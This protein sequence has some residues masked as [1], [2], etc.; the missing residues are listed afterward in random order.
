MT[1]TEAKQALARKLDIDYSDIA[2]NGLWT[3]SD[4]GGLI[5]FGVEKA[6]DFKPW[7]FTEDTDTAAS[8]TNTDYYDHPADLM[9]GS[10]E[11]LMVGGNEFTKLSIQAYL[12]YF[13]DNPTGT[14]KIWAERE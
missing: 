14:D 13:Q 7:P 10:I 1:L 3:D 4:L 11:F 12:R 2:N 9:Q 5:Q 6:W 8:L